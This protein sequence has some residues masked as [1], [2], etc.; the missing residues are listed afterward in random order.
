MASRRS[1]Q[2]FHCLNFEP[3]QD[4]GASCAHLAKW[5]LDVPHCQLAD[6]QIIFPQRLW[7]SRQ[8]WE[9]AGVFEAVAWPRG[10]GRRRDK[11]LLKTGSGRQAAW[12]HRWRS[13]PVVSPARTQPLLPEA[14][15]GRGA[16][17]AVS[18]SEPLKGEWEHTSD[19]AQQCRAQH[20]RMH[21]ARC[22]QCSL[23]TA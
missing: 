9:L 21:V 22:C 4:G 6:D 10:A 23:V 1:P 8:A 13:C 18:A 7:Q 5:R 14:R 20:C 11:H 19:T 12:W 17:L 2:H 16:R 3:V 15:P